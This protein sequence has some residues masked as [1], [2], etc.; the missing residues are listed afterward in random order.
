MNRMLLITAVFAFLLSGCGKDEEPQMGQAEQDAME[1]TSAADEAV[2]T[3]GELA[4]EAATAAEEATT[5]AEEATTAAEE[6]ATAAE[7]AAAAGEVAD[8]AISEAEQ[9]VAAVEGDRGKQVYD[10][11]C[12]ACHAQGIA[13]AP[14]LGD[15]A[16]WESRITKD[17]DTLVNNAINGFQGSTG[18]MPPKGGNMGLSDEDVAAAVSYMV[19]QAQ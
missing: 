7:E 19:E 12:F 15:K 18:V 8:E 10:A 3:A 11:T 17:M 13:G 1:A 2:D 5:A 6:A 14:K 4:D 16:A 9:A